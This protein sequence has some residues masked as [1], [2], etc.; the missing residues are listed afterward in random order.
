[1]KRREMLKTVA[2]A[3]G[4]LLARPSG[5]A[6][7]QQTVKFGALFDITGATGDI[8]SHFADGFRDYIRWINER[9]GI[10]S[11]TKIDLLFT[12]YQYKPDQAVTYLKKL[13]EQDQVPAISGWGTGDSILM[14]P[15]IETYGVPYIPASF[16]EG[17]LEAPN[18]WI[19]LMGPSYTDRGAGV[20]GWRSRST[21]RTTA[22][23]RSGRRRP[24][25][26]RSAWRSWTSRR[27]PPIRSTRPASC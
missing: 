8:G 7:Q 10:R 18:D 20:P 15:Q 12:D 9:G 2:V 17:L 11:G 25:A 23:L 13:A 22:G 6:A 19:W 24:T 27:S 4:A 26:P 1:M 21:T 14:K 3:A 5:A 16:H